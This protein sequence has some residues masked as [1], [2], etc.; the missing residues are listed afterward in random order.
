LV[1]VPDLLRTLDLIEPGDLVVYHGSIT[2]RHGLYLAKP[3]GLAH[4]GGVDAV[5]L[6]LRPAP[7][8]HRP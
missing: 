7:V 3:C 4:S 2:D 6:R 5:I 8:T 1:V